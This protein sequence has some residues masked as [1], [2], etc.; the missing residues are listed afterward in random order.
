M[1]ILDVLNTSL[2]VNVLNIS[3]PAMGSRITI[4]SSYF[5]LRNSLHAYCQRLVERLRQFWCSWLRSPSKFIFPFGIFFV[6]PPRTFWHGG[7]RPTPQ[8]EL[9]YHTINLKRIGGGE[10][11]K[12]GKN[13]KN[14]KYQRKKLNEN[15]SSNQTAT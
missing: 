6:L 3:T 4:S 13:K 11:Y 15:R 5:S 10:Y 7:T 2:I 14:W 8:P 12:K 9:K 1:I